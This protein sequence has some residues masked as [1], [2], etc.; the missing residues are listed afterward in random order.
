MNLYVVG[1]TNKREQ[2]TIQLEHPIRYS[3]W[4]IFVSCERMRKLAT[5]RNV[6]NNLQNLTKQE[7][8]K[9]LNL[10]IPE[11]IEF[12]HSKSSQEYQVVDLIKPTNSYAWGNMSLIIRI[13][14]AKATIYLC[15]KY[16]HHLCLNKQPIQ[17][18]WTKTTNGGIHINVTSVR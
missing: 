11:G 14:H 7:I 4:H 13:T 16:Q 15:V 2:W 12:C 1:L 8:S 18:S 5:Q 6:M 10:L 17:P 9:M 3:L